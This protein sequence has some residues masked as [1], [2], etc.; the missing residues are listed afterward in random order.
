MRTVFDSS[1][2]FE[3]F[4]ATLLLT[5]LYSESGKPGRLDGRSDRLSLALSHGKHVIAQYELDFDMG[6]R[7]AE[8][9]SGW[10]GEEGLETLFDAPISC[11]QID[12]SSEKAKLVRCTTGN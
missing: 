10:V 7:T 5:F 9:V 4:L 2:P 12:S 1:P 3:T 6:I 11:R 8:L